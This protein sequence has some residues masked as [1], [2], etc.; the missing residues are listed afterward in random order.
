[1]QVYNSNLSV[2]PLY[3]EVPAFVLHR[4]EGRQNLNVDIVWAVGHLTRTKRRGLAWCS[5]QG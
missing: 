3:I 2:V 1:M 5:W 4:H